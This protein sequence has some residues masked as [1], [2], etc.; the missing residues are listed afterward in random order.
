[1]SFDEGV[2]PQVE[3]A[4]RTATERERPQWDCLLRLRCAGCGADAGFLQHIGT[5][6]RRCGSCFSVR[7]GILRAFAPGREASYSRFVVEYSTIRMAEGR[8]SE[9]ADYY[10]ALPYDDLTGTH[11]DQWHMRGR[12]YRH[13]ERRV[14]PLL[15][16]GRKLDILDLGAG[17]GWLS[18]RLAQLGHR[19]V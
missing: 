8:G 12:T 17:T 9:D 7:D 18:Y 13:F 5:A 6:C 16:R 15:D 11:R 4:G 2:K 19:P 14:L 1:M 3:E 10:L